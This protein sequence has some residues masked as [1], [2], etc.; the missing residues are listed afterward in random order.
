[1]RRGGPLPCL[2][3]RARSVDAVLT[4][5]LQQ[6][7]VMH[8][9]MTLWTQC[10]VAVRQGM[11]FTTSLCP[12]STGP[13]KVMFWKYA[14][15][16]CKRHLFLRSGGSTRGPKQEFS[17]R[18]FPCDPWWCCP[19]VCGGAARLA[20]LWPQNAYFCFFMCIRFALLFFSIYSNPLFVCIFTNAFPYD[21]VLPT[22]LRH[23]GVT[24]EFSKQRFCAHTMLVLLFFY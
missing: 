17:C 18:R 8:D 21:L 13:G 20:V 7:E 10:L 16:R 12:F 9:S 6:R 15:L 1:M 23:G 5:C 22:W 3:R 24:F 19:G 4:H 14:P 11:W 2:L